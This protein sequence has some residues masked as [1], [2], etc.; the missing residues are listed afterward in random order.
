MKNKE[1]TKAVKV[2]FKKKDSVFKS[3]EEQASGKKEIEKWRE[4]F[5]KKFNH[6]NSDYAGTGGSGKQICDDGC[7]NAYTLEDVE[8][9]IDDKLKQRDKYY[10]DKFKKALP[11]DWYEGDGWYFLEKENGGSC[12]PGDDT[13][14]GYNKAIDDIEEAWNK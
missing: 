11:K 1:F 7:E 14:D 6:F 13:A 3:L 2:S 5:S 10:Q 9:F 12:C 4:E 8:S